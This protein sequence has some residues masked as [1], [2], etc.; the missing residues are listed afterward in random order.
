[1]LT[2]CHSGEKLQ[3]K[4]LFAEYLT[5]RIW[6]P[7]IFRI[8]SGELS[9]GHTHILAGLFEIMTKIVQYRVN[10]VFRFS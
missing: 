5:G 9:F 10:Q 2:L 6:S 4:I 1:M 8:W 3:P 7:W